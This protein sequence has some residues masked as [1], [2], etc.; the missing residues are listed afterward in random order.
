MP[1][2][3]EPK[4]PASTL[5]ERI[6]KYKETVEK[7]VTEVGEHRDF[8]MKRTCSLQ[9][10]IDKMEFVKD[11]Q[12]IATSR[13]DSEKYLVIGADEKQR[14]FHPV[15]N[16]SEFDEANVRQVLEKYLHP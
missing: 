3:I 2:P 5:P 15:S 11:V 1:Q 9:S 10:L 12:S 14:T 16:A 4:E 13:I 6:A 7:V 8:E